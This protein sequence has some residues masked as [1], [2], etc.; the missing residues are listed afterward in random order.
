MNTLQPI[1]ERQRLEHID[2]I[3]GF[4]I[5]GILLVNMAHFS[6]PDLYLYF[7]GPD[8]FFMREWGALDKI[9]HQLLNIFVQMKFITM[10]SFLFG[11]GMIIMMERVV[12]RGGK[13]GFIYTRRLFIL[14]IFGCIHAFFIWDGDIL[15]EYALLGFV[16]LLFRN[17][18][19]KT[20]LIW[21]IVFYLII[22]IPAALMSFA[23]L[24]G[25]P[26]TTE[27]DE[28][29]IAESEKN[30]KQA[31]ATYA[32]GTFMEVAQQR[33]HDRQYY[34]MLN[35]MAYLN[36]IIYFLVNIPYFCMFLL[37]VYFAKKRYLHRPSEHGKTLKRLWLISLIIGLPVNILF[38]I[39]NDETLLLIGGPFLML[40]YVISIVFMMQ[41]QL[42]KRFLIPFSAVGKTALSNYLLQSII[43]TAIF[44]SYGL[45]LYGSVYPFLGLFISLII[46]AFQLALSNW[47]VKH[48]RYGPV[49]YVW[50]VLTYGKVIPFTYEKRNE[51]GKRP[52]G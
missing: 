44:Y 4:A 6:Y 37:G 20:I 36:P 7:I 47:W 8:N 2:I 46:F 16:L 26:E 22:L 9:T 12:E 34:M 35:G 40:F 33:I 39:T 30:A 49:E 24:A 21:A 14:L 41:H 18:K 38:G 48:F 27:F 51:Q 5:F 42:A 15:T 13:F 32:R 11:F 1:S 43:A 29:F 52:S 23:S 17:R 31:L 3:R 19:P 50:R 25:T 10:F 45:G 28:S